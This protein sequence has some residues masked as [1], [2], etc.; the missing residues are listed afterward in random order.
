MKDDK[1]RF[2][3]VGPGAVAHLHSNAIQLAEGAEL[4]AIYGRNKEK[5]ESFAS[6]YDICPYTDLD[7]FLTGADIDAITIATPSGM[8]LEIATKA[9][10]GFKHIIC[11]KPLEVTPEKS[12]EIIEACSENSVQLGVFFQARFDEATCLAKEAIIGGRLGKILFASC[13]MRWYRDQAYYDSAAWRGTWALDGGGSL[14]NQGIHTIDL[15]IHLVGEPAVVSAL[16]GP[17]THQRIEVEDNLCASVRFQNGAI[18]TIEVSTSCSPGFPRK[19]EISGDKGTICIEDNRIVRWEF[20]ENLPEDIDV[21]GKFNG[22]AASVGGAADPMAI[23]TRGHTLIVEDFVRSV[24][25]KRKPFIDGMEGKKAVD[26]V[27]AVYDSI[28]TGNL[29]RLV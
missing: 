13:Q 5:T 7:E 12:D 14:M 21:V 17:I 1:L 2:G 25:E 9:A 29:V 24:R 11:E 26:F 27:C 15:L 10:R 19:V 3:I 8:H 28:R 18:G 23:E 22:V 20:D 4:V 16:Q 6:E